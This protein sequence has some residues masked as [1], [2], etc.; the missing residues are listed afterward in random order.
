MSWLSTRTPPRRRDQYLPRGLPRSGAY[1]QQPLGTSRVPA[2]RRAG[3]PSPYCL[4]RLEGIRTQE[5]SYVERGHYAE[6]PGVVKKET[7]R[8]GGT[9]SALKKPPGPEERISEPGES[10]LRASR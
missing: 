8:W 9:M 7:K 1:V 10:S 5:L 2:R 3:C 6:K 4:P